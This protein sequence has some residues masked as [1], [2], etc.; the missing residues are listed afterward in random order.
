M[1]DERLAAL[2]LL[3][4]R[5]AGLPKT[6]MWPCGFHHWTRSTRTRWPGI[7]IFRPSR[8]SQEALP[9]PDFSNKPPRQLSSFDRIGSRSLTPPV[10]H[11]AHIGP[12]S[13]AVL[14][15][16]PR[17]VRPVI[18]VSFRPD[19]PASPPSNPLTDQISSEVARAVARL[20]D[21]F[22]AQS[23][24]QFAQLK[25]SS[26]RSPQRK[27]PNSRKCWKSLMNCATNAV[28]AQSLVTP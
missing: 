14:L 16:P 26:R 3:K 24:A 21:W 27:S 20:D 19:R 7:A 17:N 15:P 18:S 23:A 11:Y 22:E 2:G 28:R 6:S 13:L 5:K 4:A 25:S 1:T 9:P 8:T 12:A 10:V